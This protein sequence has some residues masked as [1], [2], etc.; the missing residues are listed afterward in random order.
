M[1]AILQFTLRGALPPSS[2]AHAEALQAVVYGWIRNANAGM[3]QRIHDANSMKPFSVSPLLASGTGELTLTVPCI[4]DQVAELI[5]QGAQQQRGELHLK[6]ESRVER[7]RLEGAEVSGSISWRELFDSAQPNRSWT[8]DF[9]SPTAIKNDG[10]LDPLPPAS[11]LLRSWLNR[12]NSMSPL[13]FD[14]ECLWLA[15][16][17]METVDEGLV[18]PAVT[19]TGGKGAYRGFIGTRTLQLSDSWEYDEVELRT[20]DLLCSFAPYA[21]TGV[22]T[23]RGMGFTKLLSADEH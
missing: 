3:A 9:V 14:D 5:L 13:Q 17:C 18:M 2:F 19:R 12:L 21:S 6:A 22:Q 10:V 15:E 4:D 11:L 20:I 16:D 8:L 1:P 23:T 7:Y